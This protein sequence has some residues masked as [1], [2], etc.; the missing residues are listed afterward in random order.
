MICAAMSLYVMC[1]HVPIRHVLRHRLRHNDWHGMQYGG[2]RWSDCGQSAY[3]EAVNSFL[4]VASERPVQTQNNKLAAILPTCFRATKRRKEQ[5]AMKLKIAEGKVRVERSLKVGRC[6]RQS[7]GWR[8]DLVPV[9]WQY[10][11]SVPSVAV[12]SN[13]ALGGRFCCTFRRE[14]SNWF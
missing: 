1:R 2:E 8:T 11:D 4:L 3:S 13:I 9:K 5:K 6:N 7:R 14:R 10:S 12:I